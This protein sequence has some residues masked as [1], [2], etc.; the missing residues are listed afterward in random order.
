MLPRSRCLD[1]G[2]RNMNY[3]S[4]LNGWE[5]V[6]RESS[7]WIAKQSFQSFIFSQ[8]VMSDW[9][10]RNWKIIMA[11]IFERE[12]CTFDFFI[13]ASFLIWFHFIHSI[14]VDMLWC[15]LSASIYCC[16]LCFHLSSPFWP[17]NTTCGFTF[18]SNSGEWWWW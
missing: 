9:D 4:S 6:R 14:S 7:K 18:A 10:G 1:D 11:V 2:L 15:V 5:E 17:K 13:N 12:T 8:H 16:E 3:L